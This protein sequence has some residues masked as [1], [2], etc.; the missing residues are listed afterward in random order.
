[1]SA[2]AL[3]DQLFGR[4]GHCLAVG[5]ISA[6][7]LADRYGTPLY[8]YD[9]ALLRNRLRQLRQHLP[10]RLDVYFS[11]KA[12]PNPEIIRCFVSEGTGTEIASGAEYLGARAAGC[13]PERILFA[14]PGKDVAE[15]DLVA[16][17][18]I[19]EIH[20]ESYEE[21]K[22]LDA[23]ARKLGCKMN[24]A[25]RVNP[26]ASASG[27]A[28]RMGG[29]PAPFGFDEE[30][31]EEVIAVVRTSASL[32]FA[33]VHMFAGTQ[34]LDAKVLVAQW[35]HAVD[36][37]RRAGAAAGAPVDTVDFGGGLGIPY[38]L[39]ESPLDLDAVFAR[40]QELF[41]EVE[42]DLRLTG[43]QFILEPGRFLAGPAGVYLTRIQSIKVS[44]G[45]T[46][47]VLNGGMHHHLAASGNLGQ[48]IKRDYPIVNASR[49]DEEVTE[50]VTVVGPLCT[51][52]DTLARKSLL[53][54]SR[55]GDLVAILQSGAYGLTASPVG[56]LS[57]PMPAEVLVD[58]GTY[59]CIRARGSFDQP[60]VMLP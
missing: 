50:E 19:G 27:G 43:T 46:F 10:A 53:P 4:Q 28:M 54:R 55:P 5:G 3:V 2:Y 29:Q 7:E 35:R 51:P 42:T 30:R 47:I 23:A 31:L 15:L 60:L 59:R 26:A 12:N 8:I 32:R 48:V 44:R 17:N 38:F 13:A 41:D 14:G 22:A 40:A 20:V 34:I 52:L 49:I 21:L 9:A 58:A 37:G 56:F 18:G 24:V 25:V 11:V 39:H 16:R 33:G 36:L 1:M 45:H 6:S 57:H